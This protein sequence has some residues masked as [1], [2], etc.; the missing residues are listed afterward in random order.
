MQ[1]SG[2]KGK[3]IENITIFSKER[4]RVSCE[5]IHGFRGFVIFSWSLSIWKCLALIII[6]V[7]NCE[8]MRQKLRKPK[9]VNP[10]LL[11]RGSQ[12]RPGTTSHEVSLS[13]K[14]H[15]CP[16]CQIHSSKNKM[17]LVWTLEERSKR[18]EGQEANE[19]IPSHVETLNSS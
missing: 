5:K 6:F 14:F 2:S 9:R 16:L 3:I 4:C 17:Q 7:L 15:P 10:T 11:M 13:F 1:N 8:V 12:S 19:Q 18:G